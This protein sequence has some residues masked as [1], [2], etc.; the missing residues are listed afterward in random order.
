MKKAEDGDAFYKVKHRHY[1]PVA[2]LEYARVNMSI[3]YVMMHKL[4]APINMLSHSKTPKTQRVEGFT[5]TRK[6]SDFFLL[7]PTEVVRLSPQKLC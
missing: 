6:A 1:N 5:H 3:I 4:T 7:P 2:S